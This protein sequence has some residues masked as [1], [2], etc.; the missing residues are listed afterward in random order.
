MGTNLIEDLKN[1]TRF[2]AH[3]IQLLLYVTPTVDG[4]VLP[5]GPELM[6]NQC[7]VELNPTDLILGSNSFDDP[8]LCTEDF[9]DYIFMTGNLKEQIE[10]DIG[11]EFGGRRSRGG[12]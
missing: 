1:M 4:W 9:H 12:I 11:E 5:H 8:S 6:Y 3:T 2:P 7:V 10:N